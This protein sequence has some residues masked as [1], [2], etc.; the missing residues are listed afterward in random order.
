MKFKVELQKRNE[1]I[2]GLVNYT[3]NHIDTQRKRIRV[4]KLP[5]RSIGSSMLL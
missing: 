2:N 4:Y 1:G 5:N 3:T